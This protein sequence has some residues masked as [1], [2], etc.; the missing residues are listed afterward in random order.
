MFKVNVFARQQLAGI[1]FFNNRH[2]DYSLV[3]SGR[4]NHETTHGLYK[5]VA[6]YPEN[7]D[8]PP[9]IELINREKYPEHDEIRFWLLRWVLMGARNMDML[10]IDKIPEDFLKEMLILFHMRVRRIATSNETDIILLSL[11]RSKEM[12]AQG[13]RLGYDKY[14]RN[15]KPKAFSLALIFNELFLSVELFCEILGLKLMLNVRYSIFEL[16]T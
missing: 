11:K 13:N 6:I 7:V 14:P 1:V 2:E 9:T 5:F 16:L 4:K 10:K 8:I 3:V 12:I 15:V